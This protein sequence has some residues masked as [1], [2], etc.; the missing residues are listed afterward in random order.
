MERILVIVFDNESKVYDGYRALAELDSEGTI[1]IHAQAVIEKTAEGK[2]SVRNKGEEFPVRIVSGT[3][4]GALI[5][6]LGGPVGS[7]VGAVTGSLA[8]GTWEKNRAGVKAK[9][10]NEVSVKLT[11]GKWAVVSDIS[12]EEET[13]VDTRMAASGGTVFRSTP[14]NIE[15][16]QHAKDVAALKAN[17]AQLK[18]EQA[19]SSKEE[20]AKIRLRIDNLNQKLAS[21]SEEARRRKEESKA[22][23]EALK[24]KAAKAKG[25]LK[26][27]IKARIAET[28]KKFNES[29][30][31]YDWLHN[32]YED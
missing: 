29:F 13:P 16:Q 4:I 8:G 14:R 3:A 15:H 21:E 17:I 2:V 10:I 31:G 11:P 26:A 28:E 6:L 20:K 5:G 24:K 1:S 7:V 12:E 19:K 22:K 23:V 18:A 9:F 30:E 25:E 27:K 32:E